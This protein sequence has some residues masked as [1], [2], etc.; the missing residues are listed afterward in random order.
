MAVLF[1][2]LHFEMKALSDFL[3]LFSPHFFDARLSSD[4]YLPGNP[5]SCQEDENNKGQNN[6]GPISGD[7]FYHFIFLEM[8]EEEE[9]CSAIISQFTGIVN[10]KKGPG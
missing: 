4:N 9:I 1:D 8:L 3:V 5:R 7:E 6:I 10:P 2:F